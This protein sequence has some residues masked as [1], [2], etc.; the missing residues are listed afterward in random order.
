M[1]KERF[2]M[3]EKGEVYRVSGPVVTAEGIRPR[4]Y[5]V[6]TVGQEKLM[7]E[8]IGLDGTKTIIQVYEDTSGIRP[9]EEVENTGLPLMV[10]LGPGLVKSIYD[11]IQRP[12]PVL[13][14]TM[15]DFIK[16][17]VSA[18]GLDRSKK[19]E[20]LPKVKAGDNVAP[21]QIIGSVQETKYIQHH[22]MVPPKV[23]GTI[24]TIRGGSFTVTD[25]VATLADGRPL[26]LMQKWPVRLGRPFKSRKMPDVPLITGQRILDAL[27]PVA[28]G[29]TAAIPGPFGSGK[30]VSG[31]TPVL[32]GSG[33]RVPMKD[34][35]ENARGWREED[36]EGGTFVHLEEP[37]HVVG[38]D[39][40]NL[41]AAKAV[42]VYR[43]STN[44]LVHIRTRTS[45]E[46]RATPVHRLYR[47]RDA[48]VEEVPAGDLAEGDFLLAPRHLGIAKDSEVSLPLP[49]GLRCA[50]AAVIAMMREDIEALAL[51]AGGKKALAGRLGVSYHDLLNYYLGRTHPTMLFIDKVS[52]AAGRP[53]R[54]PSHVM[55]E[56]DSNIMRLPGRL[57]AELGEFLGYQMSEGTIKAGRAAYFYNN[58]QALLARYRQ[59]LGQLFDLEGRAGQDRTVRF[60]GVNSKTLVA[61]LKGLG[62]PLRRKSRTLGLPACLLVSPPDVLTAFLR[63]YIA[64]DGHLGKRG[65][66][67][68]TASREMASGLV[69]ALSALGIVARV[70]PKRTGDW[71]YHRVLISPKEAARLLPQYE[72]D[73]HWTSFDTVPV[74]PR[75][76][77]A[78]KDEVGYGN[79]LDAGVEAFN[80]IG[81]ESMGRD[82]F[83]AAARIATGALSGGGLAAFARLLEHFYCDEIISAEVEEGPF[84]VYDLT[85]PETHNFVGGRYPMLLHNTVTQQQLSKWSDAEIVIYVGCGERGNEMTEVLTEFPHLLDP[86]TGAPLMDR[87]VLIANTSNMP[88]AAREASVYTGVTIGEYYRDMGLNVSLMADSTS[89]WAEALREI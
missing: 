53:S 37:L 7:G 23:S 28:K 63:A 51:K 69:Y 89:R 55:V 24:A 3:A 82:K 35:F 33:E 22:I 1:K 70:Q 20:F 46:V 88:V 10:E 65:V 12:L 36:G 73:D 62:L 40:E 61:F 52:T 49:P 58:D 77:E 31:D 18:P 87:T 83:I 45:R 74:D 57:S 85:V 50:D 86:R 81:G 8:V 14:E 21:G 26:G 5:D 78:L 44:Q 27:F 13:R 15:G 29:G 39:G 34:L 48:Q 2:I 75:R 41:R 72:S 42:S 79:L 68:A 16:R 43:G 17:G 47:V 30:C 54:R 66:E 6:V 60:I 56:R 80:Y 84:E 59:L 25:T 19:W 9:G 67:I 11:G 76:L 71:T 38:F 32:L 64:G 4:M